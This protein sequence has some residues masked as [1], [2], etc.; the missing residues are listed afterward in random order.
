MFLSCSLTFSGVQSVGCLVSS[1]QEQQKLK[2]VHFRLKLFFKEPVETYE[3][4]TKKRQGYK[5]DSFRSKSSTICRET[6]GKK[7]GYHTSILPL[8]LYSLRNSSQNKLAVSS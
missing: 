5:C 6:C 3:Q 8:S 1:F 7:Y 4:K 2:M